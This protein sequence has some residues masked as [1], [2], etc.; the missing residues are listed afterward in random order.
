M[1]DRRTHERAPVAF[2]VQVTSVTNPELSAAGEA[3]DISKS[4][5]G[6]T[7][8]LQFPAGSLVQLEIA[9]SSLC[10]FV[11]YSRKW[12]APSDTPFARNKLWIGGPESSEYGAPPGATVYQTGI[13]VVEALIGNSGLSQLLKVTL[14][15]AMPQLQMAHAEQ[16]S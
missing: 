16:A 11:A 12:T 15:H 2:Q 13:E 3:I 14:E 5:I 9:D 10:G 8:P 7:L 6:M 1:L 4:G